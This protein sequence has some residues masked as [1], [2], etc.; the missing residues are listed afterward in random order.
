MANDNEFI[1]VDIDKLEKQLASVAIRSNIYYWCMKQSVLY[2]SYEDIGNKDKAIECAKE[3]IDSAKPEVL[4]RISSDDNLSEVISVIKEAYC[5]LGRQ[6]LFH[7]YLIAMEFNRKPKDRFYQPRMKQLR[8]VVKDLQDLFERKISFY[9]LEM[10]PRIGKTTIGLFFLSMCMGCNPNKSSLTISYA[11]NLASS[12]YDGILE[13]INDE[14]Y[15]YREIFPE[16]PLIATDTKEMTIDLRRRSRYKS[17]TFRSIDGQITG[18]V[19][20]NDVMYLDDLIQ[21]IEE[22]KNV[23]RMDKAWDKVS[24]DLLQRM[25]P[26]EGCV[27]LAIG[28]NWSVNDPLTRLWEIYKNSEKA[29][30]RILPALD[31]ITDESNF[32]YENGIGFSTD[33]YRHLRDD[34]FKNDPVSFSCIYQQSPMERTELSFPIEKIKRY[35][36]LPVEKPDRRIAFIDCAFG[37]GDYLCMP[38]GYLYGR[39]VYIPEIVYDNGDYHKTVPECAAIIMQHKLSRVVV[40][41]NNGGTFYADKIRTQL[42]EI[43][44][45]CKIEAIRAPATMAKLDRIDTFVPDILEFNFKCG[46]QIDVRSQYYQAL[47]N[48]ASFSSKSNSWNKHDDCPDALAGLA[49]VIQTQSKVGKVTIYSRNEFPYL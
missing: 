26:D 24:V 6:G 9:E 1:K 36:E 21:N 20:A 25:K 2:K 47:N 10:P 30:R 35:Y 49:Q 41:A 31:P 22:A 32:D 8:E 34:I 14:E 3:L 16:S 43:G 11:S 5:Y 28:T 42:K 38:I 45:R 18:G 46:E 12:F 44:Y 19:E 40:E 29:R 4:N 27:L 15:N 37:G 48:L 23:D 39:D 17:I 33:Y 13:F 7:Y